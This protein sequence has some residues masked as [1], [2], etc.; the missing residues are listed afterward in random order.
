MTAATATTMMTTKT[1]TITT[2]TTRRMR[3]TAAP[4]AMPTMAHVERPDEE[5]D[6][7]EVD[8]E[9]FMKSVV[10]VVWS[11]TARRVASRR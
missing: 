11:R 7:D 1:A 3:P 4:T 6:P 5:V 8:P 2:A 9:E 10:A